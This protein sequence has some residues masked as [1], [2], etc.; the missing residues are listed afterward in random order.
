VVTQL[1]ADLSGGSWRDAGDIVRAAWKPYVRV[2]IADLTST[3]SWSAVGLQSL[4]HAARDLASRGTEVRLVVWSS[5]LYATLQT[6]GVTSHILVF[7][8][9]DSALR[10]PASH[11]SGACG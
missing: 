8:N 2:L 7:A 1:P 10:A 5:E 6:M 11:R 4:L 9:L 3:A